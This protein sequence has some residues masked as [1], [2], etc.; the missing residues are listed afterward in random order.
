MQWNELKEKAKELGA[1][2]NE[3]AQAIFYKGMVFMFKEGAI[4]YVRYAPMCEDVTVLFAAHRTPEQ[5][6]MI[7]EALR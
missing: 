7:M 2:I 5:M 3:E 4:T 6:L 1:L